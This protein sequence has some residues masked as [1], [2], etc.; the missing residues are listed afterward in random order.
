MQA[1]PVHAGNRFASTIR[2]TKQKPE[3]QFTMDVPLA[4]A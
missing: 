3:L 1:C 4:S 2:P